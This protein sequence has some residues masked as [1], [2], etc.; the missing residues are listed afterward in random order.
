MKALHACV[1]FR[2]QEMPHG[3]APARADVGFEINPATGAAS[4]HVQKGAHY[5]GAAPDIAEWISTGTRSFVNFDSLMAWVRGPLREAFLPTPQSKPGNISPSA[6]QL[7]NLPKVMHGL[8][9]VEESVVIDET[10]L[11]ERILAS[12]RGQDHA[13]RSLASVVARHCARTQHKRPAVLFS[14]GPSG[15]GKTRSAEILAEALSALH[16]GSDDFRFLRLDMSEY[17]EAHRVSQLIG[18]P[19]GYLGHHEGSQLLD[20]LSANPKCIVLFDEIEK[21]HPAILKVLMNAMDAGRLSSASKTSG[22]HQVDCRQAIFLFTSN[23]DANG[24]LNELENRQGFGNTSLEDDVCRRRMQSAGIP[25]EIVGR[26]GRFLVFR[27]LDTRTRAEIMAG[28]I[29]EIA[30][31][32]GVQVNFVEPGVVLELMKSCR[33]DGFGMRPGQFMIDEAL[34]EAFIQAAHSGTKVVRVVG[35]PFRCIPDSDSNPVF[36]TGNLQTHP[37]PNP[38]NPSFQ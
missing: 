36:P 5:S 28:T 35:S 14:V 30:A 16:T 9:D 38:P 2:D 29:A 31:E 33:S 22:G 4:L 18:S 24:I 23:L 11:R 1:R 12:V 10:K 6:D 19:Q 17:Q 7:T 26:I 3:C 21:A 27:P 8:R 37:G 13:I 20:T 34:G 15:V 25:P 32:Y